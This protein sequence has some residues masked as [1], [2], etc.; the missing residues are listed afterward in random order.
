MAWRG[1]PEMEDLL[2]EARRQFELWMDELTR[3]F[4]P[5]RPSLTGREEYQPTPA[6]QGGPLGV[7]GLYRA[8]QGRMIRGVC[9]GLAEYLGLPV[10]LVRLIFVALFFA[11]GFPGLAA[12][13]VLG[14]L[15]PEAPRDEVRR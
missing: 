12:Y 14:L 13:V 9:A 10:W 5:G 11:G 15:M 3:L 4:G 2:T 1:E 7:R 8:R 6:A